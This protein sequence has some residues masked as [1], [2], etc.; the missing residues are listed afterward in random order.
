MCL[1]EHIWALLKLISRCAMFAS[2]LATHNLPQRPRWTRP[3][4][5][6]LGPPWLPDPHQCFPVPWL[7]SWVESVWP[8][9]WAHLSS[10]SCALLRSAQQPAH[11]LTEYVYRG[12]R[13]L[14]IDLT[15]NMAILHLQCLQLPFCSIF[16]FIC[17]TTWSDKQ[18]ADVSSKLWNFFS[19]VIK[20]PPMKIPRGWIIL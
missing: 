16:L 3:K 8:T 19:T 2:H 14:T 1:V 9:A 15:L 17:N 7:R 4:G 18:L 20:H 6:I 11:S 12:S 5:M 10:A 13:N